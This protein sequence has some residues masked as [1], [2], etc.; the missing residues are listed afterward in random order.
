MISAIQAE[1]SEYQLVTNHNCQS[2]LSITRKAVEE[3]PAAAPGCV[4]L[5]SGRC[6]ARAAYRRCGRRTNS[7]P[8]I[9]MFSKFQ[10]RPLR[11]AVR[12]E[13]VASKM[14]PDIQPPSAM[15]AR[16]AESTSPMRVPAS[17]AG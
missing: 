13:S 6:Y 1:I 17:A 3:T 4:G 5:G 12:Y 9:A 10:P 7:H 15:P 16:V 11:K 14:A 8:A 2:Q